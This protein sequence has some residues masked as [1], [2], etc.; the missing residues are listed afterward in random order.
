[1]IRLSRGQ[2]PE[3]EELRR[4]RERQLPEARDAKRDGTSI[5]FKGYNDE[6]VKKRLFELQHHNCAY[7]ESKQ[8]QAAYRDV[9]HFRPK[10]TY[11]W[12]AWS[13]NNLLFSCEICNRSHKSALFPLRDDSARLQAEEQPPGQEQPLLL[14]PFDPLV[15]PSRE[16]GFRRLKA[17]GKKQWH[18]FGRTDRGM[19]TIEVCGLDRPA[20]IDAYTDHVNDRVRPEIEKVRNA[21]RDQRQLHDAWKRLCRT[22]ERQAFLALSRDAV[23]LLLARE[24]REHHLQWYSRE[25]S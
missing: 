21:V 22:L 1:M 7:C 2:E 8:Q 18:P 11:W 14:D 12:L 5:T 19:K 23:D 10:D 15:D 16:I 20:L 9:D 13:W 3:P 6:K 17:N 24:I 4:W 25:Q